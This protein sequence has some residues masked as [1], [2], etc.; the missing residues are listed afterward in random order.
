MFADACEELCHKVNLASNIESQGIDKKD[1]DE[2]NSQNGV[3]ANEDEC[4]PANPRMPMVH[5]NGRNLR[6]I[7]DY[8]NKFDK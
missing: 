5:D 7:W 3:N 4:T 1:W 8:K 6:T 2:A